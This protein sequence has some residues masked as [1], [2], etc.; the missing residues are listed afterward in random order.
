MKRK[1]SWLIAGPLVLLQ[2]LISP[3]PVSAATAMIFCNGNLGSA[4]GLTSSQISG[5]QASGFT[6]MVLFAMSV[7][8]NGSFTYGGQTICSNGVYVGPSNWGSLLSQCLTAPSSVTRIE[9]CLGGAGDTSWANI[10][11]LIAANGTNSSTVL[12]QNLSALKNALGINAID[13]DDESTYDSGSA[14]SFGLMCG[15]LGLKMT[16]CPYTDTSYWTAVKSGL[17]SEV[18]YI[19]LQCYSGGAGNDPSSWASSMGVPVSQIVPGYWDYERNA[20]FLTNM[21][22]WAGE[23]CTGGFLWPS[24]TGCDPPADPGEMFQYAGWILTA[25]YPAITN[26]YDVAANSAYK[27]DGAPDGLSAGGQNGGFGFEAWTFAIQ[28]TGGAFIQTNG[29]SG[30]SFDLWNTSANSLTVAVRPFASPLSVGQSFTVSTC[31]NSLD[32]IANTNEIVL[33][34]SGGNILFGYWHYGYEA[35][36]NN[37]E[38]RDATTNDGAALNFQYAYQQ[39]ETFTFTLNSATTYTFTDNSTGASFT[40]RISNAKITHVAFIR[41]NGANTPVNGQDFQFDQLQITS[42][43]P[44]TFRVTPAQGA[45]S[46]PETNSIVANVAASSVGLNTSFASMTVDGSSVTPTVGGSSSLLTVSYIPSPALSAGSVHMAKVVVQDDNEVSHT[47]TWSF[48]TGFSSL[49]AVLAGP[50]TVSNSVDL[51]I[52][53]AGGDPWLGT[54]YL[55]ASSQ[56]LFARFSMEFDTTNDTSSIYTWGGMDFFQGSNEK[57]LFGKN[58]GSPNWSVAIDGANG[59]DLNPVVAV[60]PS[61]WHTIVVQIDYEDG[62]VANET[63]WL[64]PD[65]TQ[66]EANQPQASVTL[67]DDNTFDNIRLRCGFNDASAT[68]SNIVMAATS[69]QVGFQPASPPRIMNINLSGTSLSISATNGAAGGS[70][71]LLQSTN[72]ALPLSQWQTN[73]TGNFDSSGN[74]STGIT[75]TATNRQE[76]YLLKVH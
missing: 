18:D 8:T 33:E 41:F 34:D 26:A 65:F 68:F 54:N 10:K 69:A 66:T 15:A 4:S 24:C 20:T 71:T 2:L 13:S 60:V 50:F 67:S 49:P 28:K 51:T 17:G 5:F 22:T 55:S 61:D 19:Y 45:L 47:N 31:L 38:Y 76:F 59:P 30:D 1:I 25:F 63:V 62:T 29:P 43:A 6:T 3:S 14:I 48:T 58:G 32:T 57:L 39:F 40:G 37:G 12:Y 72:L 11:N 74:L 21:M 16:L 36:A 9:M 23:G 56:T 53:T 73:C 64:D 7:S 75:N 52:F 44:P 42:S 35:N 46:V 27:G 70:W